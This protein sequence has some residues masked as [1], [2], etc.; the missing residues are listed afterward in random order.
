[1]CPSLNALS[2]LVVFLYLGE[3]YLTE[4]KTI[5]MVIMMQMM[6]IAIITVSIMMVILNPSVELVSSV[7]PMVVVVPVVIGNVFVLGSDP[8]VVGVER[9]YLVDR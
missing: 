9:C 3:K 7:L 4:V 5:M 8:D 6:E 1:M 2:A